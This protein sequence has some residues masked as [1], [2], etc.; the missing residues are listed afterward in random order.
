MQKV[1]LGSPQMLSSNIEFYKLIQSRLRGVSCCLLFVRPF[2]RADKLGFIGEMRGCAGALPRTPP[3]GL[4]GKSPWNPQSFW[5]KGLCSGMVA[6]ADRGDVWSPPRSFASG[7]ADS[8]PGCLALPLR[9]RVSDTVRVFEVS[10]LNELYF[11][12]GFDGVFETIKLVLGER[13]NDRFR[14][15][16][17]ACSRRLQRIYDQ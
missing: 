8:P 12:F 14:R 7:T 16:A 4:S 9:P 17:G 2:I 10:F 13:R 5:G 11:K 6:R 3:R 15:R 1:P